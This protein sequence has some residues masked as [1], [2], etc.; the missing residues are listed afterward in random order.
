MSQVPR[1]VCVKYVNLFICLPMLP[2]A[3]TLAPTHSCFNSLSDPIEDGIEPLNWLASR[4]L[5]D[6]E[7]ASRCCEHGTGVQVRA[8]VLMNVKTSVH[9][10]LEQ[11]MYIVGVLKRF[12]TSDGPCP[13]SLTAMSNG[14]C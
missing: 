1:Y 14:V 11:Q 3:T 9:V 6:T 4:A 10:Q 2:T 12:P 13:H 5:Q 7:T 8:Y